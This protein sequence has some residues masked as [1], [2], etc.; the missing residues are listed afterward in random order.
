MLILIIHCFFPSKILNWSLYSL[1]QKCTLIPRFL[2]IPPKGG[3][4]SAC[5]AGDL[6]LI[7][8]L[9]RSPEEGKG[10]PLQ[11]SGLENSMNCIVHG[12]AKNRT[13]LSSF[14]FTPPLKTPLILFLKKLTPWYCVNWLLTILPFFIKFCSDYNNAHVLKSTSDH[15][16]ICIMGLDLLHKTWGQ[17]M[18]QHLV[19]LNMLNLSLSLLLLQWVKLQSILLFTP[20]PS[21]S[22][23]QH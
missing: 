5:N 20:K 13:Q 7:P 15:Y 10:Y 17:T 12:V 9:G 21:V 3:K 1:I 18:R 8:R 22:R 6:G 19:F 23:L 14:I 11:Y 16:N 2:P 4:E